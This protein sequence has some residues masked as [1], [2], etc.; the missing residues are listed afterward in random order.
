MPAINA[1]RHHGLLDLPALRK[2]AKRL[3]TALK[4]HKA[5]DTREQLRAL[6]LP[7]PD[8][9]LADT[10][11]LV[12]REA[13][14]ASWPKLK[15]HADA[16]AFAARHPGFTADDEA[17]VQHW[18]CGNDIAH[19][20]RTAGFAGA[21]QMF[22]DPMVMGPVCALPEEQ[23]WQVRAAYIQQAFNLS[24]QD[25][26]QRQA[27]QRTA[28][29]GLN[30]DSKIVLWCEGDAYDQLFLI[31]VLA[32]LPSLPRRLELIEITQVPGVE[33]FIGIG[34]LAPDLLAWLWPQRRALGED[35]LALARQT[36]AAYT[37]PDP[38]AW[39]ALAGLQHTALPLLG[40]A[41]A[42]QLQE[43]PGAN[44]GLSLTERL[45]LRILASRGELPAGRVFAQLMMQDEPLPYLGDMMFHVLLQP[46][47]HAPHPLLLEGP[48]ESWAQ[49]PLRLT[50]LAEQVL[51]GQAHWLDHNPAQRWVGGVVID[52]ADKPWV[53]SEQGGVWQ[54]K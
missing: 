15:A 14:F 22:E 20:L 46:L 11:W 6:G 5:D 42:R 21:F 29:A 47:I 28:L 31:R 2:R 34:Q 33:R 48:G 44:D 4:N 50:A 27:A 54:R 32:S 25:V 52:A 41:L 3:L 1:S 10:Q 9:R 7:G 51:A 13:G 18:R 19:S 16:V 30:S 39:A 12:A 8:Y 17:A 35:V 24:I 49:R 40:R 38:R 23:Y 43:L 37:A 36:W 26:E 45:L 53:V